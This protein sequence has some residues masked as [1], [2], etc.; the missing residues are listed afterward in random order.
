MRGR[1]GAVKLALATGAPLIP[2][3][4]WG[5]QRILPYRTKK[6]RLFP[7]TKVAIT[8]GPAIDLGDL[9]DWPDH[10]AA[11]REGTE[12]LMRRLTEMVGELRG[13]TPP[14]EPYDQFAAKGA[15]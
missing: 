5:A 3:A 6:L 1:P 7:P 10:A 15:A 8:V 9:A 13:E 12:R 2:V 4:Q 14:P 11:A